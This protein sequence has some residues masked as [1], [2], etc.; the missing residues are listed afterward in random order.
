MCLDL[1]C[2]AGYRDVTAVLRSHKKKG[3][4]PHS[5]DV[6]EALPGARH[7]PGPR[8]LSSR[9]PASVP[10]EAGDQPTM[11]GRVLVV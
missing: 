8:S 10:L 4:A 5:G 6:H 3:S 9:S 2:P 7:S 11:Q 1:T